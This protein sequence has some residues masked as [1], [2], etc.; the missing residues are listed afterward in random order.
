MIFSTVFAQYEEPLKSGEPLL[1]KGN[2]TE[3][4]DAETRVGKLRA[5]EI[6]RLVDAR[7]RYVKRVSVEVRADEL[8]GGEL[9]RL[10]KLFEQH[11]G[12]CKAQLVIQ[13]HHAY[14][15]GQAELALPDTLWVEPSDMFLM[16]VERIFR[17]KVVRLGA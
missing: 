16:S 5:A 2:Y 9:E 12:P 11:R 14:G 4:G 17:R 3:E 15:V 10:R 7:K 13:L 1:I 6:I 8:G